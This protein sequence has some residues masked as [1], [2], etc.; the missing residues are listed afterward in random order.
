MVY[1]PRGGSATLDLT[2]AQGAFMARW[3]DPRTGEF[4][5]RLNV[6]GGGS[7]KLTAPDANDWALQMQK[8]AIVRVLLGLI[9][10]VF[11]SNTVSAHLR[12]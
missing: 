5:E 8:T 3:F 12:A 7:Q 9:F 11:G 6:A 1:L 2:G 4:T 10:V